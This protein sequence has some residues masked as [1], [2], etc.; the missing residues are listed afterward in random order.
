MRLDLNV[1]VDATCL[2]QF[3]NLEKVI[4]AELQSAAQVLTA[5]VYSK[6]IDYAGQR[7]HSRH[8][9]YLEGLKPPVLVDGVWVV[10]LD[11]KLMWIED[12]MEPYDMLDG[13]LASPK[14][15]TDKQ[16]NRYVVVPFKHGPGKGPAQS[17]PAQMD[18]ISTIKKEMEK[19]KI[20]WSKIENKEDGTPKLG[21]I[22]TFN[23]MDKPLKSHEGP[24]QG[25]GPVGAVRQ[26]NT[27][28]PFLQ[29]VNVYQ[30]EKEGK[31]KKD[32]VTFRIASE[33]HRGQK[34]M[35]PGLDAVHILSDVYQWAEHE[36]RDKIAPQISERII[37]LLSSSR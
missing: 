36:M 23:I 13:L 25:H 37:N 6:V 18:L 34:W 1:N 16:G 15:K 3:K 26:G 24:G 21:R 10:E 17:T 32:I 14:A 8:Q 28:I 9:M 12:G 4:Q 30:K 19:R 31:I 7:L 33:R 2:D 22:H 35:H 29:G 5:M 11:A 20:P 27:G